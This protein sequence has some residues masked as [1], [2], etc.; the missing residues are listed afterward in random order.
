MLYFL[1]RSIFLYYLWCISFNFT[2]TNSLHIC[3]DNTTK[4]NEGLANWKYKGLRYTTSEGV[5][6]WEKD[7]QLLIRECDTNSGHWLPKAVECI[8]KTNKNVFCP[9]D[10]FEI[11][12]NDDDPIC[13]KISTLPEAYNET[14]CYGS[15]IIIPLDLSSSEMTTIMMFLKEKRINEYWLP[16]KRN[17]SFMPFMINLPGERWR[18]VI[19]EDIPVADF[20]SDLHCLRHSTDRLTIELSDCNIHLHSVCVFKRSLSSNS[21]C[22]EGFGALS[23]QPNECYGI[24]WKEKDQNQVHISEYFEKRNLIRMVLQEMI[25]QEKDNFFF[26]V[27]SFVDSFS[28]KYMVI[29]NKHEDTKVAYE[30]SHW[31][32]VLSKQVIEPSSPFLM[33]LKFD[34]SLRELILVIYHRNYLW[35]NGYNDIGVQCFTNAGY[36]LIKKTSIVLIWENELK[37]RSIFKLI[38]VEDGPGEY[39]CEGHTIFNFQWVSTK[40]L[41]AFKKMRGHAFATRLDISCIYQNNEI[42][43]N[44]CTSINKSPEQIGKIVQNLLLKSAIDS[45]NDLV[46]H[47][48]RIMNIERVSEL[49]MVCW[50]HVMVS[51]KSGKELNA[52]DTLKNGLKVNHETF[53]SFLVYKKL[54]NINTNFINVIRSTEYCF[55]EVFSSQNLMESQWMQVRRGEKGTAQ[56]LCLQSNGIPYTRLCSGDFVHGAHWE[57]LTQS[58]SCQNAQEITQILYELEKMLMGEIT[59]ERVLKEMKSLIKDNEKKIG[60]GDVYLISNIVQVSL[61]NLTIPNIFSSNGLVLDVAQNS[62]KWKNL[63]D[64]IIE[65]YNFFTDLDKDILSLSAELNSTSKFL[66]TFENSIDACSVLKYFDQNSFVEE[67][68]ESKFDFE[69]FDYVDIGVYVQASRSFLYFYINPIVSNVSGI[70]FFNN[71]RN[72]EAPQ[73]LKGEFC[74]EHFRFL[75]SNHDIQDFINDSNL[76]LATYVP[77]TLLNRLNTFSTIF[78]QINKTPPIVVIKIHSNDNLFQQ[79]NVE[80]AVTSRVVSISIPGYNTILPEALPLILRRPHTDQK[81][82]SEQY[83]HYWNYGDWA[84]DGIT[85]SNNSEISEDIVICLLTHLTPFAYVVGSKGSQVS[86][87]IQD[88]SLDIITVLASLSLVGVCCI[89]ITAITLYFLRQK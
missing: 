87:K 17:S 62:T 18:R 7:G 19:D 77:D 72:A 76:L 38:L 71:D 84:T 12:Q 28:D 74:N 56:T 50:A 88:G 75:Q 25:P 41:I 81:S 70:A 51:I 79:N 82:D 60:P 16:I 40:R 80:K 13:L 26:K 85:M 9:D 36:E 58:I 34:E 86:R 24:N 4:T 55:P 45:L 46:M 57:P 73:M 1:R 30:N 66:E 37:T 44:I 15:N 39:W 31:F 35:T 32:P 49:S 29:M 53:S 22:P 68:I 20:K 3:D 65:I 48:L 63:F 27:D 11:Q 47:N 52:E 78:N 33:K 67:D 42:V 23:Y 2:Q 8:E 43:V 61:Q 6:C 59:P 89:I 5:L 14:F 69:V 54:V 21:G 83:C 64:E 10:L